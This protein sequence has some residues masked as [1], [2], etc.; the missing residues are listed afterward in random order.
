MSLPIMLLLLS[1]PGPLATSQCAEVGERDVRIAFNAFV[2]TLL[3]DRDPKR[4]FESFAADD[5]K[6][7]SPAFGPSRATTI[8]QWQ[9]MTQ[10]PEA[11]FT[12]EQVA[13][14]GGLGTLR[15][16]GKLK[17]NEPGAQVAVF[18]RFDCGKIAETWDIFRI[19]Q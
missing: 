14:E 8:R 18:V 3:I 16:R 5:L 11:R 9:S 17:P 4:A 7:H 15:F 12:I 6:Q 13:I 10:M 2:D 19:E 1:A